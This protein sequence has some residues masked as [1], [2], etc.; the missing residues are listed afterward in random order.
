MLFMLLFVGHYCAQAQTSYNYN[1]G[2]KYS[3]GTILKHTRH[4]QNLADKPINGVEIAIEWQTLNEEPWH[5][6]LGFP[7]I[8]LGAVAFD[9]GNRTM[10]GQLYAVYPYLNFNLLKH[11]PVRVGI[12]AGAGASFLTKRFDN[13]ATNPN[14]LNTGNAAIGSMVNV[15]FAGGGNVE[16]PLGNNLSLGVD[17]NWNHASNGSF[18]QPNSGINMI[19]ASAGLK[20]YPYA[21]RD[22]KPMHKAFRDISRDIQFEIVASGGARELYY[23]DNKLYPTASVVVGAFRQMTNFMRVGLAVDAFYDGVYNGNT[24]FKRTYLTSDALN[25]KIRIGT[26]VQPELTFGRFSA[27]LHLGLYLYN[28]L[29]N[30]EPY[31]DAKTADENGTTINKPLMYKYDI[32]KEDGWF[33]SRAAIKYNINKHYFLSLGL[34]THLQKAEFIEWGVGYRL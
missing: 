14:D 32:E 13:T 31:G 16:V 28:P 10:L 12:K 1:I 17:L 18:Y 8:G 6:F 34:K 29:K 5:Q 20:Y 11:S 19:N 2:A 9:L 22:R 30:K 4:L 7:R 23:R 3:Y 33:Y 24:L 21:T 25:N 15:F 27:G 26:S